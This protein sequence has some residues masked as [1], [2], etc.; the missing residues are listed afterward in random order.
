M[1]RIGMIKK[2]GLVMSLGLA[3]SIAMAASYDLSGSGFYDE[4]HSPNGDTYVYNEL[5]KVHEGVFSTDPF[6]FSDTFTFTAPEGAIWNFT[7]FAAFSEGV[8]GFIGFDE[9]MFQNS[10]GETGSSEEGPYASIGVFNYN[11]VYGIDEEY[12]EIMPGSY[13]MSLSG[14]A[15]DLSAEYSIEIVLNQVSPVPEPSSIALMLGGLGLVGFMA[16]RRRQKL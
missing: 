8:R 11:G 13:T 16:A 2:T 7:A 6:A 12:F 5:I 3:S 15:S 9:I 4:P 1:K 14:M 10:S